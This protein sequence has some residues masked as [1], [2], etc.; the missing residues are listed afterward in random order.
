MKWSCQIWFCTSWVL[1]KSSCKSER[2]FLLSKFSL[3]MAQLKSD[4]L[5]IRLIF[6]QG[7]IQVLM[8][9]EGNIESI[10]SEM[11]RSKHYSNTKCINKQN[12]TVRICK[13]NRMKLNHLKAKFLSNNLR[14]KK[15]KNLCKF[16]IVLKMTLQK[17]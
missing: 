7:S 11:K 15:M 5:F 12:F 14:M 16:L 6:L 9:Q 2:S 1:K 4:L 10:F 8:S 17:L 3:A 13:E